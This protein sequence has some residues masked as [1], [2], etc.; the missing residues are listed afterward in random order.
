[1]I[2]KNRIEKHIQVLRCISVFLVFFYHLN[3]EFFSNG[4]LG[5]DIFFLISGYVITMKLY[6]DYTLNNKKINFL[7][8]WK[9]RIQ[10]IY[11]VLIF[12]FSITFI[13]FLC[14]GQLH[15]LI[16]LFKEYISSILGFSNLYFLYHKVDYFNDLSSSPFLHA[17]S[18][19]VEEQFY[20]LYPIIL[21]FLL[22]LVSK[23]K[24]I[25]TKFIIF[26]LIILSIFFS[27]VYEKSNPQVSFYFPFLRFWEIGLG[28]LLFFFNF[29]K[30]ENLNLQNYL[31]SL[32][33]IFLFLIIFFDLTISYT[34][35]NLIT[36][37]LAAIIIKFYKS[38]SWLSY[39]FENKYLVYLGNI[40]FSLY[41]W[42][43]PIIY[44][45]S[46]YFGNYNIV[47]ASIFLTLLFSHFSYQYIEQKFR[48]FKIKGKKNIIFI[49]FIPFFVLSFLSYFLS[50]NDNLKNRVKNQMY[51]YNYLEINKNYS[52]RVDFY[53]ISINNNK[54][55]DFCTDESKDFSLNKFGLVKQCSK[56]FDNENLFFFLGN[57]HTVNFVTAADNFE[58]VNLYFKHKS[59]PFDPANTK[60]LNQQ[61]DNFKKVIFVSSINSIDQL[62]KFLNF[63][64][65][66]SKKIDTLL[67]GPVP[68]VENFDPLK[69]LARNTNCFINITEDYA[70]RNLNLL[71]SELI[72]LEKNNNIN[73]FY[74]YKYLCRNEK[75]ICDVYNKERDILTHRDG[76]HLTA[77]GSLV[78][79]KPLNDFI[80]ENY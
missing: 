43:L 76:S 20:L 10:R 57:S 22:Y 8:F 34:L 59:N 74:P 72:K 13:F 69:C 40:S 32:A 37:I 67:I 38:S 78:L 46:L 25:Q 49:F 33:I 17:W 1:M 2:S 77:E 66:L 70:S 65:M 23:K 39:I 26:L 6:E 54:I 55:Y 35:K 58:K 71:N 9:K 14:F 80:N 19:A 51:Q 28:C 50:I 63:K 75:I 52:S 24:I 36:I 18:L 11:P 41:L 61:V 27:L 3:I 15:L 16:G 48:Y 73:V 12:S 47:I 44:F 60:Y 21:S 29:K 53:L 45:L 79:L 31:L 30:L 68:N 7:K 64:K 62:N 56:I 5:V 42:H 4:Y